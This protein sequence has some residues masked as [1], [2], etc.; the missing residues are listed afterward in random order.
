MLSVPLKLYHCVDSAKL[1][2]PDR[3]TK[4]GRGVRELKRQNQRKVHE[5]SSGVES[6]I[7]NALFANGCWPAHNR[8]FLILLSA[9]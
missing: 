9:I 7:P 8:Y 4:P 2:G 6:C 5:P 3:A 1:L